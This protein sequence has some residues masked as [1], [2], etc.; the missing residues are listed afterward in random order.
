VDAS[1]IYLTGLSLGGKRT[2]DF[3]AS[4]RARADKLAAIVPV[5]SGATGSTS[6]IANV[7]GAS[8][9]MWFLNNSDDPYI[10][11]TKALQLVNTIN[12]TSISPKAKITIH[13]ASG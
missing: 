10:S 8:V 2:W 7:T 3:P 13:Q 6:D 12:L 5:C 4:A 1:R 11:A 9:P